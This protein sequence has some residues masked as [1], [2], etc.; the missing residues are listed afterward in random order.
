[1]SERADIIANCYQSE[2]D[3]LVGYVGKRLA[4]RA[5]AEDIVED[6]F[7]RILT[8]GQLL[9]AETLPALT[10]TVVRHLLTDY[11]RRRACRAAYVPPVEQGD[12]ASRLCSLHE[13]EE[14]LERGMARLSPDSRE[15]YRLHVQ[16]GMKISEIQHL[17][18]QNYKQLEY[19]LGVARRTMRQ[20]MKLFA[21]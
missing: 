19:S 9:T 14:W 10:F 18:H 2:R 1:M 21:S 8:S 12:D 6:A 17:T 15:A 3:R 5:E 16:G 20:H 11:F 4:N 7:E 13:V